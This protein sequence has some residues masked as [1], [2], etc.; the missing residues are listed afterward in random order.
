VFPDLDTE[1]ANN[2]WKEQLAKKKDAEKD[3]DDD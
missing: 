1:H 3:E 2:V